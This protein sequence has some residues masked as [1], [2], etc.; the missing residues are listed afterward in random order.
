MRVSEAQ[1]PGLTALVIDENSFVCKMMAE[2]LKSLG[3]AEVRT[4]E[5]SDEAFEILRRWI[6]KVIVLDHNMRPQNGV[7]FAKTLRALPDDQ[8]RRVPVVMISGEI[9]KSSI[10]EARDAGIE[11]LLAKPVTTKTLSDRLSDIIHRPRRFVISAEYTGP[12]RRRRDKTN[13]GGPYR[14]LTD[15]VF[16]SERTDEEHIATQVLKSD[17]DILS[18]LAG[19]TTSMDASKAMV[20]YHKLNQMIEFCQYAAEPAAAR[21]LDSLR[22]YIEGIGRA[23][24]ANRKVIESHLN[25]VRITLAVPGPKPED[26]AVIEGLHALVAKRMRKAS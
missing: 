15:P 1:F 18:A 19:G 11:N 21:M 20:F 25:A 10:V 3:A 22:I 23:G 8:M 12:D 2:V 26:E 13:Y 17:V 4:A 16:I 6:P 24:E 7:E 5:R 9:S 14:R